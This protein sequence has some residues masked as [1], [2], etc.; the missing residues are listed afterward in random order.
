MPIRAA[1]STHTRGSSIFGGCTQDLTQ[2]VQGEGLLNQVVDLLFL[3]A[4]QNLLVEIPT[5]EDNAHGFDS[6]DTSGEFKTRHGRH[7]SVK[8]HE[9]KFFR[10]RFEG[11]QP[12]NR[13]LKGIYPEAQLPEHSRGD[14]Q[15]VRLVIDEENVP[16]VVA[17]TSLR[18]RNLFGVVH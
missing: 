12:L 17:L 8:K 13:I 7:G 14:P 9:V 6:L 2:I 5:S 15:N 11:V 1:S 3:C 4:S 18:G 16:S 10:T